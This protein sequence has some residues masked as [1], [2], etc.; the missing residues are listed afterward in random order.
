M[1][2]KN[3]KKFRLGT[4]AMV[5]L[6]LPV[7]ACTP[8]GGSENENVEAIVSGM[9]LKQ[10]VELLIGTGMHFEMPDSIA[11]LYNMQKPEI[12]DTA[13][14][15]M[16]QKIR[17]DLPGAAGFIAEYPELGV[18]TQV[19]ADGPAGLRIQPKRKDDDQSYYCTA[20][21]I[22]TVLA[23]TWDT[24][25]VK[26]VGVAMGKEVLEYNADVLLAPGMNLQRDPLCGRNFEYYSEDPLVTGKMAAA[27]VNGVQ[28]NGVGTSIKHFAVNN[29]ETNRLSVNTIVSERALRELY[30]KGF[31]IA[32]KE[33]NPWTVM[34]AYNQI[35]GV[36]ASENNDL[37]TKVLRDD[38]GF[39]GYVMTDWGAGSD[40]VAQM[41]AGND[42]IMPGTPEYIEALTKAVEDGKIDESV[43]DR[44]LTRILKIMMLTPKHKGYEPSNMPDLK[45]HA[46]ITR[47]AATE[48][49]V[50]L[51]NKN[52]AL[53]LSGEIKNLAVFGTTSYEFIAG[54]TGSGDVN[55]AYT[56]SLLDGLKNGGLNVNEEL[57]K[58]YSTYIK[59]TR[60][61]MGKPK[62]WLAAIMGAKEPVPEMPV[63]LQ[64][65]SE[66][67]E[68]AEV[69]LITI[70]R[71]SGEGGDREA[72]PGD[73]YLTGDEQALIQNVSEAFQSKG[74]KVIVILNIGGVIETKSWCNTPDAVLCAW[75][76][77]QE[78]G[79]SVVDVLTGKANPS[80]K[81]AVSWPV[82]YSDAPS[83]NTF[84]GV[85]VESDVQDDAADLSGFSFNRRV[86]WEVV[87]EEDIYVGYRYYET[88][89][90]PVSYEFGYG[91]SYTTF[92]YS[93]AGISSDKLKDKLEISV[94]VT[95]TGDMAGKEVVQV[96]A[97]AP[98]N[99]LEKP[100]MV[101]VAFGK[102]KELAPGAS[103]DLT[104][105]V[106]AN[107]L[108]SFDEATSSFVVEQGDYTIE[109]GASS[110]DIKAKEKFAVEADI[111][112][113]TVSKALV[114]EREINR[115]TK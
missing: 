30:L 14:Y 86:P 72:I 91:L 89:K 66:M 9:T 12:K 13:Y 59:E 36:Y 52:K 69:A 95:N 106:S 92:E 10:K 54:G 115:L 11:A 109:I 53:P 56:I 107:E 49:M 26:E 24:E 67:A 88:F 41:N 100:A 102:T 87:Y 27:M 18:T 6:L 22:A 7:A 38:W 71:N 31:E 96:Y 113:S 82:K 98:D 108:A 78:A 25:L 75:Q 8:K 28:S 84:P 101:L 4:W 70:G 68:K 64:L 16:V 110:K 77:G 94:T 80:G 20:F 114:P 46:A 15:E 103:Q 90:V 39:K 79:N 93:K 81:M 21:P 83:S 1:R 74:K 32:V 5:S 111:V 55:E 61:K 48:G 2:K 23:S 40:V 104:F 50:L 65:A 37:L 58:R 99:K 73:F 97:S 105:T 43:L 76:P 57:S 3:R 35:N 42:L 44:N 47:Q 33:A 62:N 17:K 51:E 34:S 85:A 63:T 60:A 19:L 29:Q 112:T 45:A